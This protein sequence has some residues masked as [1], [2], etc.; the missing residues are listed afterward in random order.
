MGENVLR[1][2]G[3]VI[4]NALY[5]LEKKNFPPAP[6]IVCIKLGVRVRWK[7]HGVKRYSLLAFV[8]VLG[9]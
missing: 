3:N 7:K 6:P 8:S 9:P 5:P 1:S 2:R 4:G